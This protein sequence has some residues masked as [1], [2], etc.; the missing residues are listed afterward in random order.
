M[1]SIQAPANGKIQLICKDYETSKAEGIRHYHGL[2]CERELLEKV[3]HGM[4][5]WLTP[6]QVGEPKREN[7]SG[8]VSKQETWLSCENRSSLA[9]KI[10]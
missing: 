7:E 2:Q 3:K 9:S 1:F 10:Q 4:D 6:E 5:D 8:L